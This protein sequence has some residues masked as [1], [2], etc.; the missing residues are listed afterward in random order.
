M[1]VKQTSP[2]ESELDDRR[3]RIRHSA[4]HLLADAVLELFPGAKYAI[5]PPVEDGFYYDFDVPQPFTPGDLEQ[6]EAVMRERVARDLPFEMAEVTRAGAQTLFAEQPYKQDIIGRLPEGEPITTCRHGGFLDLCRGRHVESTGRVAAFKLLTTAGAYWRGDERNPML[7]RVYGSAWES[8]EALEEHLRQLREAAQR[9]HRR[10]GRELDLFSTSETVGPGLVLWHPK[11]ARVRSLM[12]QVWREE[13]DRRGYEPV[14]SPHVGKGA[15]W[16]TSGHLDFYR[17]SMYDAMDVE[18]QEYFAKPMNCPFHI[19]IYQ[20]AKR[21]YRE[22]PVRYTELGAVYR[23]E[24]SGVLHGLLRVRGFTQDDAH[25]F[26]TPEQVEDEVVGV[27]DF[28]F[29]LLG[30]FGFDDY[31][32]FLSTRPEKAVGDEGDWELATEALRRAL[33]RQE[34][35]YLVDEG[36][37]AFYG[38]KLDIKVR[39]AIGRSWQCTTIQFDFNLP[40]RFGLTYVGADGA[41]HRPYMVHRAL[42]GSLERFFGILIE[43]YAGAFPTWLAPVQAVVIPIA[44]RHLDYARC[45]R[46]CLVTRGIRADLDDSN[47]RMNAKLRD[48]ENM[49]TPYMII[50][51]DK[52]EDEG[53]L[54]IRSRAGEDL[55]ALEIDKVVEIVCSDSLRVGKRLRVIQPPWNHNEAQPGDVAIT[56]DLSRAFGTAHHPTTRRTLECLEELISPGMSVLDVGSGSAILS[57]GAAKLGAGTVVGIEKRPEALR[58][59]QE[60]VRRNQVSEQVSLYQG[61]LPSKHVPKGGADLILANLDGQTLVELA[62]ELRRALKPQGRLVA[63]G[64]RQDKREQVV[65]AF[66]EAELAV[67]DEYSDRDGG[68]SDWVTFVCALAD[69]T[70]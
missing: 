56:V 3:Y 13:H 69:S 6:L 35:E 43:H 16:A 58:S 55:T 4:A 17:E 65:G 14:Y 23:Y 29:H 57:I 44:D 20:S 36:G 33:E 1:P 34:V 59:G 60:N 46:D 38:P 11:G 68:P 51:G 66:S 48:A 8:E 41:E 24:R 42:F 30:V 64:I 5:G 18:G 27:L 25:I 40:Q 19:Q 53:L 37:G 28:A 21:S 47:E 61:S 39:D 54:T 2:Q 22:L 32:V 50:I 10:L 15:L 12:E 62:A 63:A 52:E 7:Q 49:K 67:I 26:C 70:G 45:V 31:D 9:D